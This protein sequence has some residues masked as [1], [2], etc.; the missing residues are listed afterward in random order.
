MC[1]QEYKIYLVNGQVVKVAEDV[2]RPSEQR[3]HNRYK[4]CR[5]DGILS[6]GSADTSLAFIP[7]RNILY[8]STD[9]VIE[10]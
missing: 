10:W 4:A 9:N 1:F 8:I 5:Q 2:C 3:L 6:V 7:A